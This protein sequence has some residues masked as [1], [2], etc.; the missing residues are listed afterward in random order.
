MNY[1][2]RLFKR[3]Y[4]S[5]AQSFVLTLSLLLAS[6]VSAQESEKKVEQSPMVKLETSAGDITI[7][8]FPDKA[9]VTVANFLS[10]V[11]AGQYDNTVFHRVIMNFMVQGGGFELERQ[12]ISAG[13]LENVLVEK[14]TGD[15]IVNES[16][17]KLH[18]IRGTIAM[19]RTNDP[20]SA[21]A[22]FFINQR[23]NLRLD[24]SPGKPGYTVFGEVVDGMNAVD[25]I[26]TAETGRGKAVTSGGKT[27]FG[28][29]PLEPIYLKKATRV[30]A[31]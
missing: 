31:P 22:Q 20:D 9:P 11:D 21:S 4:R 7:K 2:L 6:G 13:R 10:Y 3:A 5:L 16:D 17:N 27:V 15:P 24:W 19:A 12:E 8:L 26:A 30:T 25:F 14:P 1:S 29:V 23:S 28:D 18:N